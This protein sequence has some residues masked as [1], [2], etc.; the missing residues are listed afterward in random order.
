MGEVRGQRRRSECDDVIP[1]QPRQTVLS[2]AGSIGQAS[3]DLLRHMG[4]GETDER[5]QVVHPPTH[6][7]MCTRTH[8][9][10]RTHTLT[11]T[12]VAMAALPNRKGL[13]LVTGNCF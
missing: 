11:H 8:I 6:A 3:G 1:M 13:H 10:T 9:H 5:F 12:A 7:R 4:E 2:A